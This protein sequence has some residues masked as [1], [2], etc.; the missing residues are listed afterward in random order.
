MHRMPRDHFTAW[1]DL[2][3]LVAAEMDALR[4]HRPDHDRRD[5]QEPA[6][7]LADDFADEPFDGEM[8]DEESFIERTAAW[9]RNRPD[10]DALLDAIR[11]ALDDVAEG[12][13]ESPSP[14]IA[15][16]QPAPPAGDAGDA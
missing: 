8:D 10:A 14:D 12:P 4:R 6:D 1:Q 3:A 16:D 13:T 9:L 5:A 15:P 7:A 11:A 2:D